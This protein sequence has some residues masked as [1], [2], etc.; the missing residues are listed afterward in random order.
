M[1]SSATA[2][3]ESYP[4]I[5]K[6]GT[7]AYWWRVIRFALFGQDPQR[8]DEVSVWALCVPFRMWNTP[9]RYS[10]KTFG[11]LYSSGTNKLT[12]WLL[13]LRWMYLAFLFLWPFVALFRALRQ[14]LGGVGKRYRR[15]LARPDLALFHSKSEFSDREFA[16][17]RPDF[18][19][20]MF[21]AV[22]YDR[23]KKPFFA[24]DDKLEFQKACA[25]AG[26]PTPKTFTSQE[27]AKRGGEY[28]VKI[29]TADLGFGVF[30]AS[31]EELAELEDSTGLL[32][33][34][35]LR[36]HPTLRAMFGDDA[37]LSTF[38][39]TTVLDPTT[40]KPTIWRTSIRIGRKGSVV[41]NTAQGG[42]WSQIDRETGTIRAGVTK[43]SFNQRTRQTPGTYSAHPDTGITFEGAKIPW[44]D[45][46]R[47]LALE[48]HEKLAP[49]ALTL[50]WDVA[51][52]EDGPVLLEVNVWTTVYD[53]DP[54]DDAFSLGCQ[55]I[56]RRL[57]ATR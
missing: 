26:L 54:P 41:D 19:L 57:R 28:I 51:L 36:N 13:P 56:I 33:Q 48:A 15:D 9:C 6:A 29:P 24:L 52:A 4:E 30:A 43:K 42:I 35:R 45:E 18:A 17:M 40:G 22:E 37:P 46:G 55:E 25:R 38:R 2:S 31:A 39:V 49:D 8:V 21:Y 1:A 27:A 34:E 12:R 10:G 3:T 11:D 23:T 14:G 32:I 7:L 50:G 20:G 47:K 16:W 44:W 53:Y 5:A